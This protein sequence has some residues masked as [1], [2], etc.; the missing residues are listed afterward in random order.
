MYTIYSIS[1]NIQF[2]S[3]LWIIK[4]IH[5]DVNLKKNQWF[6]CCFIGDMIAA[7]I[8]NWNYLKYLWNPMST[9]SCY[10]WVYETV[11]NILS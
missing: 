11:K 10:N 5:V 8:V 1:D 3:L 9:Y 6:L 7:T 2:Y 4:K